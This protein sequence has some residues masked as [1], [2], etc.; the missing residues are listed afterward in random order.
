MHGVAYL[1]Q[2][3]ILWFV[4]VWGL[5][6]CFILNCYEFNLHFFQSKT[7]LPLSTY[8]SAVKVRWLLDNVKKVQRAVEEDRA[9]FGTID[10]WLIWVCFSRWKY[11][12]NLKTL[13]KTA[14]PTF[15]FLLGVQTFLLATLIQKSHRRNS[16]TFQPSFERHFCLL[17]LSFPSCFIS[18]QMEDDYPNI[19]CIIFRISDLGN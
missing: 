9:L 17:H 14:L 7:G 1:G 13:F 11:G 12:K 2:L 8:F 19:S 3:D 4:G 5:V 16:R 6:F 18:V 10:S 15:C